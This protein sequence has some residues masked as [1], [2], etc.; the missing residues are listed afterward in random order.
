MA[1][2]S[3][4]SGVN[5]RAKIKFLTQHL[6]R[7][8]SIWI[9]STRNSCFNDSVSLVRAQTEKIAAGTQA[10]RSQNICIANPLPNTV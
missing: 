9:A 5:N 7:L 8:P 10:K 3:Q 6:W 4:D 2:L 1:N